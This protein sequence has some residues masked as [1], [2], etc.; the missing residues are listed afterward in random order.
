MKRA[1]IVALALILALALLAP[2]GF[3]AGAVGSVKLNQVQQRDAELTM[4]V[5]LADNAGHAVT[6]SFAREQ[7]DIAMDGKTLTVNSVEPFDPQTQGIHYVFSIDVS[8][9]VTEAMMEDVRNAMA[10]FVE[11]FGPRD[12]A[13]IITF[14]EVITQCIVNSGDK[15]AIQEAIAGLRADEGMTALYKGVIDAVSLAA[16]GGRSAVIMITDGKNDP[17]EEMQ[18]YTKEGIFDEVVAAQVPLYCVGLNDN[19]GVDKESLAEFAAT[20]GGGQYDIPAAQ[21]GQALNSIRDIMCSAIV[22][23]TTLVNTEGRAGFVEASTFK[24]GFQPESGSFLVSNELQQNINWKNV[25][26]PTPVPTSTPVPEISLELDEQTLVSTQDGRMLITGAVMVEQGQVDEDDLY[27]VVN[28]E[29]WQLTS[30]MRNGTGFT[31]AAEGIVPAGTQEL[32]VQAEISG[33]N[34]ASRMQRIAVVA[35]TPSPSPTPAP[36]LA[37]ELDDAGRDILSVPGQAIQVTGVINVQ[38]NLDPTRLR[39]YINGVI[40]ENAS[41]AQINSNQYE[42]SVPYTPSE[43]DSSEL[44]VQI[45]LE[46]EQVSSRMQRLNLITPSPTPAPEISL[47]LSDASITWVEGTPV[48]VRGRIEVLSGAVAEDDLSLYINAGKSDM[49]LESAGTGVYNFSAEYF[50]GGDVTQIDVRARLNSDTSVSTNTEKLPVVTPTPAPTPTPTSRPEVTPPPTPTPTP[51]PIITPTPAPTP[52]PGILERAQAVVEDMMDDGTIWYA[53][54]ALALAFAVIALLIVFAVRRRKKGRAAA[55]EQ[56]SPGSFSVT[57]RREKEQEEAGT[58]CES[59]AEETISGEETT[60]G[61]ASGYTGSSGTIIVNQV[62]EGDGTLYIDRNEEESGGTMRID[63]DFGAVG[64]TMRIEDDRAI[65][66]DLT[67]SYRG[68]DRGRHTAHVEVGRDFTIGR[69]AYS[70]DLVIDDKTVSSP[71]LSI[72]Y[73]GID[74]YIM[75]LGSTNGTKLNGEKI[76]GKEMRR[77]NSGDTVTIGYTT[78][79][80]SFEARASM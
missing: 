10:A 6:G 29:P 46:G 64:G 30:L 58:I 13:T 44:N 77:V 25:P 65:D 48:T 16:G 52:A 26:V 34:I 33:M 27:V 49:T 32:I 75:D 8:L 68:Q 78:L 12:T 41:V 50:P 51:V 5:S 35:P 79:K 76:A 38:G 9:T 3:A 74:V 23:H 42:F 22:L 28:G 24:V 73:D 1:L 43:S 60:D 4:Y 61:R 54:G 15:A 56:T 17:T 62:S 71:H 80:I 47:T 57:D 59:D 70:E 39:V 45:Q 55:I 72:C 11:D 69:G 2:I 53:V 66:V 36:I 31:F 37:V 40:C 14:G 18:A 67:E 63:D 19:N 7:F 21:A 20:T